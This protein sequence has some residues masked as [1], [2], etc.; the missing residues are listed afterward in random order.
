MGGI[1]LPLGPLAAPAKYNLLLVSRRAG[2]QNDWNLWLFPNAAEAAF[3]EELVIGRE[4]DEAVRNALL[5]G[6]TVLLLPRI[7]SLKGELPNCF[8]TYYWTS[9]GEHGGQSSATGILLDPKHPLFASFPTEAHANWHW[10]D[11]LTLCQPMIL[12]QFEETYPWPKNYIPLIQPI[13]SWKT[14]V[15]WPW[16]SKPRSAPA[17]CS[18]AQWISRATCAA[19]QPPGNSAGACSIISSRRVSNPRPGCLRKPLLPCSKREPKP[20][21]KNGAPTMRPPA[22]RR[23]VEQKQTKGTK[24]LNH[25]LHELNSL[26]VQELFDPSQQTGCTA[27]LQGGY[28]PCLVLRIP[29]GQANER[30]ALAQAIINSLRSDFQASW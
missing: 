12:D 6:R 11:L 26:P 29:H 28:S 4:W 2:L 14:T 17:V 18:S 3:P 30:W 23:M 22:F 27:M 24:A 20:G 1:E 7:G 9:M 10:W 13:D 15:N 25:G 16:L 5:G 21:R 8:T 19:A